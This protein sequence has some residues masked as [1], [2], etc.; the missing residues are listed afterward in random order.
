MSKPFKSNQRV[1]ENVLETFDLIL[2][3]ANQYLRYLE[4]ARPTTITVDGDDFEVTPEEL[5]G[6]IFELEMAVT[7]GIEEHWRLLEGSGLK[8]S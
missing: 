3:A 5:D 1:F 4:T 8:E 2:D 6:Y 7:E